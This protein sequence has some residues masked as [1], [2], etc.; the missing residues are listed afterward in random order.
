MPKQQDDLKRHEGET[1]RTKYTKRNY[2]GGKGFAV[3]DSI[4]KEYNMLMSAMRVSVSKHLMEPKFHVVWANDYYYEMTGYTKEEYDTL[5]HGNC[6]DYYADEQEEYAKLSKIVVDALQSGAPRYELTLR[7]PQK[8]GSHIWIHVVGHFTDEVVD[9]VPVIY[10]TFTDVS[11]Y[12]QMQKEQVVTYDK[13]PGFVA[14]IEVCEDGFKLLYGNKKFEEFFGEITGSDL[15]HLLRENV[16]LCKPMLDEHGEDLKRAQPVQFECSCKGKDG[17]QARFQITAEC[18]D[19]NGKNPVYLVVYIDVTEVTEQR[20]KFRKLAYEDAITGGANRAGFDIQAKRLLSQADAGTYAL[21]SLNVQRFKVINDLFGLSAGDRTLKFIYETLSVDLREG[22]SVARLNADT[23]GMLLKACPPEEMKQRLESAAERV[24]KF[25]DYSREKFLLTLTAGVY[26]VEDKTLSMTRMLDRSVLAR[27][28]PGG[29][30]GNLCRVRFYDNNFRVQMSREKE[31]ENRMEDA[32][33]NGEFVVYLQPKQ[34]LKTKATAGAEALVRWLDPKRGLI[35][36]DEFIPLFERNGFVV[37]LDL[38]VFDCVCRLLRRW[39]DENKTPPPVSVNVSRAHFDDDDFLL[40]YEKIRR[41]HDVPASLLELEITET[42]V[43]ENPKRLLSGIDDIRA[44]GYRC[45]MDDFGS[46]YSSLNMLKDL[47]VD[48]LKLD[49]AFFASENMDER[50]KKVVGSIVR[51]ARDL[52][53]TTVAE[54]I[55]SA[56]QAE[57]LVETGCDLLQGYF[58]SRPVD[59]PGF[60]NIAF[61]AKK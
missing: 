31:M 56:S 23:F 40:A 48:S 34:D 22:E 52:D 57:F 58:F 26:Y 21:I 51:M 36:P 61:P 35:P 32:L 20:E 49:K 30:E 59:V 9:G 53:M 19:R 16:A 45:S 14:K 7:M 11:D 5:F 50:E 41:A 15:H 17:K 4:V 3:S 27:K 47:R 28:Q 39:L 12:V 42:A 13:L 24:N 1:A 10:T 37:R 60:E 54:G 44:R 2:V 6:A 8:G 55:E 25:N 33:R 38:Y 29:A 46:G 43:Y 18:V